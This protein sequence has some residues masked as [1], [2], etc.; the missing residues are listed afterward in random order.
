[1][2]HDLRCA[3]S[4]SLQIAITGATGFIGKGIIRA[5]DATDFHYVTADKVPH[6]AVFI[7]CSADLTPS[8]ESLIGN[9]ERDL[10]LIDQ[11]KTHRGLIYASSN[12]VYSYA[13]N[14]RIDELPRCNDYYSA[15]K[16]LGE[17]LIQD[18][19]QTPFCL[20]RIADVFGVGQ[21]HGN[22][23]RA[24]EQAVAQKTCLKKYGYGLKRRSYIY[25]PELALLFLFLAKKILRG[26]NIPTIINACYQETPTVAEI[27]E[28]VGR[29]SG[30]PLE[31]IALDQD[32]SSMDVR[33]MIPGPFMDYK[34]HYASLAEAMKA[35]VAS[36][37][38][39]E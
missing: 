18:M 7:H 11:I 1:M 19:A 36:I 17:K 15:S 22:L 37:L 9:L 23:F 20:V 35:Y 2:S 33:T 34:F 29:L 39:L 3:Y 14:C 8:R 4:P 26:E 24:I 30:L 32:S 5:S 6:G 12:N 21:R 16:V 27:I 10:W 28:M 25:E 13:L 31:H 38:P